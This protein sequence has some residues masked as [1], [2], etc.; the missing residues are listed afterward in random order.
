MKSKLFHASTIFPSRTRAKVMPVISIGRC[1]AAYPSPSPACV[2]RTRQRALRDGVFDN[3]FDVGEGAAKIAEEWFEARRA[4]QG[5]ARLVRQ[6]VSDAVLREHLVNRL[7]PPLVPHLLEP[8]ANQ[9]FGVSGLFI[10]N[11]SPF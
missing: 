8:A 1:V 10:H 3:H 9:S 11:S 6:T 4:A 7:F 5:R 2:A